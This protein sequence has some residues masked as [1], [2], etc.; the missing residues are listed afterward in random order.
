MIPDFPTAELRNRWI[1]DHAEY[2]TAVAF[3]GQ[4]KYKR[5]EFPNSMEAVNHG[6]MAAHIDGK[7]YMIYA[8]AD[9][10]D[11]LFAVVGP[12][13]DEK[14]KRMN[15]TVHL[16][17]RLMAIHELTSAAQGV[18][19]YTRVD[20]AALRGLLADYTILLKALKGL[21]VKVATEP[22]KRRRERI[23]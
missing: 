21:G 5:L 13:P 23:K 9:G 15:H 10:H 2:W 19:G 7:Q 11:A 16:T 4:G 22:P 20:K 14:A 12:V 8:V 6:R 1:F 3:M 18:D 17:T